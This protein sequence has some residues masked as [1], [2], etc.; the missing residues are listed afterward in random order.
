MIAPCNTGPPRGIPP[1]A[2]F[3]D[4]RV[5][6][7]LPSIDADHKSSGM[8]LILAMTTDQS[9]WL[10]AD[11]RLSCEGRK[12]KDDARK[13]AFLETTDGVAILGYAGLGAT[14]MGT[15]P[16]DWMGN[17][18]RG[19]NIPLERSLGVL[20]DAMRRQLP[21]H[22]R[23]MLPLGQVAGHT[24]IAPAFI[25]NNPALYTIDQV[26]SPDRR[27]SFYRFTR[28]E[29]TA[30]RTIRPPRLTV[31]GSGMLSLP[32]ARQWKRDLLSL[33]NNHDRGKVSALAVA[34]RLA[35]LNHAV[36]RKD[37]SVGA[38]CIVGWRYRRGSPHKSGGG[39]QHYSGLKRDYSGISLANIGAGMDMRAVMHAM[40]PS[41]LRMFEE[42]REKGPGLPLDAEAIRKHEEDL[43]LA[44]ADLPT[45]PDEELR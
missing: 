14:A 28:H 41:S 6:G 26:L 42:M 43:R 13:L 21:R 15:E 39:Q 20:S 9:I 24:V 2:R 44:F 23:N 4:Y 10:A 35:S 34:D 27:R 17:V 16:S 36:S 40:M 11:R 7:P 29:L 37:G 1:W 19:R 33:V 38:D 3:V 12:P 8:T 45:D 32:Q 5:A 25:G 22:L 30:P 31:G 18:L